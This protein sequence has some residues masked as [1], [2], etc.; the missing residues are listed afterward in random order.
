MTF[1]LTSRSFLMAEETARIALV[2]GEAKLSSELLLD[3][4]GLRKFPDA[5]FFLLNG[6]DLVKISLA[7]NQLQ[8]IPAKFGLK[9]VTIKCK[10]LK[11]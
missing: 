4:C 1:D 6:V 7:H 8:N 10:L 5:I 3:S 2:C 9:F 11:H